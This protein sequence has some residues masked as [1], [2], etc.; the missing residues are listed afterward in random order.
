MTR[1]EELL[2]VLE[3]ARLF[4]ERVVALAGVESPTH[5]ALGREGMQILTM[6]ENVRPAP[7]QSKALVSKEFAG[8]WW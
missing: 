6:I 4:A 3:H 5:K 1:E 8:F 7:R 2:T